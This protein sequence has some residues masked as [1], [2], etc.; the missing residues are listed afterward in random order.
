VQEFHP[1]GRR[2]HA[3]KTKSDEP[4]KTVPVFDSCKEIVDRYMTQW[5]THG[6]QAIL[7]AEYDRGIASGKSWCE[8]GAALGQ[9]VK[10]WK[11][12]R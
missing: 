9:I 1:N 11:R 4:Q 2:N 6:Q 7:Q 5:I 3:F 10:G 8:I 12:G